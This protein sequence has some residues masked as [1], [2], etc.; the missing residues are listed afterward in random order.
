MK[1]KIWRPPVSPT[2]DLSHSVLKIWRMMPNQPN[3]MVST[4][5][6]LSAHFFFQFSNFTF[7][8][9]SNRGTGWTAISKWI[10]M[11]K[12]GSLNIVMGACRPVINRN[13]LYSSAV[14]Q[15]QLT[16]LRA[17]ARGMRMEFI[18]LKC[19]FNWWRSWKARAYSTLATT[20]HT[21]HSHSEWDIFAHRIM[22]DY[23][24]AG[25]CICSQMPWGGSRWKLKAHST[26]LE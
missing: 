15:K 9:S 7:P 4:H 14:S 18:L 26:S 12:T 22:I 13:Y 3:L 19:I 10:D 1:T 5:N 20:L 16:K 23:T 2:L 8:I 21:A 24:W 17:R 11:S 25:S 6:Y